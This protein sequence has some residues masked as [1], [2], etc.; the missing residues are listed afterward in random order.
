L[1]KIVQLPF[2]IPSWK[3]A[4]I[5]N[6]ITKIISNGLEFSR[7][8]EEFEN[9]NNKRLIM[10]AVEL[11]PRQVKRFINNV[12]LAESVFGKPANELIVVQAL[13][14]RKEWWKFLDLITSNDERRKMFF[15]EY[16]K[17]KQEG[18]IITTEA[19]LDKLIEQLSED[20]HP[21]LMHVTDIYRELIKQVN[22]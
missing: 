14:F 4:D 8:A 17:I 13:N 11:N 2:H 15:N 3:E 10:K 21:L 18:K 20:N 6:S 7:L 1:Q 9:E 22:R 12:I 19:E 5:S 16:K